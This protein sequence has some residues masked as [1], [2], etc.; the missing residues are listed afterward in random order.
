MRTLEMQQKELK[1][2]NEQGKIKS[3]MA[4]DKGV[5]W[6]IAVDTEDDGFAVIRASRGGKRDFKTLD[7]VKAMLEEVNI[8][9]FTVC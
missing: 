5:N 8:K 1:E 6:N 4:V 2:L 7:A 3:V 9:S